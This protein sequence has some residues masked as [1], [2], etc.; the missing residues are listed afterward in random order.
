MV[1]DNADVRRMGCGILEDFGYTV[2]TAATAVEA[3]QRIDEGATF[4]LLFTDIVMPG[5]ITS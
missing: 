5:G 1:E 4:D 3:L 2:V